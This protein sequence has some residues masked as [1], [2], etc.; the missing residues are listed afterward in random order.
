M[1][2]KMAYFSYSLI[3][4]IYTA[5]NIFDPKLQSQTQVSFL[6]NKVISHV[7]F[8]EIPDQNKK[9]LKH[10]ECH[11]LMFLEFLSNVE[12]NKMCKLVSCTQV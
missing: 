6:V 12:E 3:L 11:N 9:K 5:L 7:N 2:Y 1:F 10:N 8:L 4:A